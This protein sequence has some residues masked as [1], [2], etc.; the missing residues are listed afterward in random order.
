MSAP[1]ALAALA[2]EVGGRIVR[3]D[4]NTAIRGVS[5]LEDARDHDVCFAEHAQFLPLLRTTEAGAVLLTPALWAKR[6]SLAPQLAVVEVSH[7]RLALARIAGTWARPEPEVDAGVHPLAFV[8][9]EAELGSGVRLAPFAVVQRGARL[10]SRVVL[11]SGAQVLDG[12]EVGPDTVLHAHAVVGPRSVVGARCV[13]MAGAIVGG[14]G[15]GYVPARVPGAASEHVALPQR[16][17]AVLEDD[18]RVGAH[19]CIDRGTFGDTRVGRGTKIDNLVQIAHNVQVAPNCLLVAQSGVAGSARLGEGA[20]VGGQAGI[21][22]H[23]HIGANAVVGGQSGVLR[24]VPEGARVLGSPAVDVQR[25]FRAFALQTRLGEL[26]RRL[27]RLERPD[28]IR[29]VKK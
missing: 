25:F 2:L 5:A 8:H 24:D 22:G 11:H 16:G 3:G 4:G 12:A 19:A 28:R 29:R 9:P 18:V 6:P 1:R 13:L 7:P 23:R 20:I 10:E 15:F 21:S 17:R 27:T 14:E 26:L